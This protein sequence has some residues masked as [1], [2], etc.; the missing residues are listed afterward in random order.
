MTEANRPRPSPQPLWIRVEIDQFAAQALLAAT[1]AL[2]GV[3]FGVVRQRQ[4]SHKASL[5]AVSRCAR[6]QGAEPGMPVFI[7]RRKVGR[8]FRV[9]PRDETAEST[10]LGALNSVYGE[11]TPEVTWGVASAWL[12]LSG[13]PISRAAPWEEIGDRLRAQLKARSGLRE[14]AVGVSASRVVAQ[15]LSRQAVPD[16]VI[17]CAPGQEQA[18]LAT[19]ATD[20]L[21]GLASACRERAHLYGLERVDQL[22]ALDRSTL[23]RRFGRQEGGRIY[24][25]VRGLACEPRRCASTG[26]EAETILRADVNDESLLHKAV[27]LTAHKATH[28]LRSAGQVARAVRL[29]LVYSDSRRAQRTVRLPVSTDAFPRITAA[30]L[31]AFDELHVRRVALKSIH[32]AALHTSPATGQRDLFDGDS[33]QK[34]R[35]LGAA[36]TDIRQRMGFDAVVPGSSLSVDRE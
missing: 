21:P 3:P 32:V 2:E 7:G 16:G 6:R 23:V 31:A 24:G 13:T 17:T 9:L 18:K 36:I 28:E 22:L 20:S 35:R 14:L 34:E 26:I 19:V 29:Q 30:S 8:G 11:W 10:V 12:D 1:P 27:R 5:F 4:D 33:Q 25:L 15:I